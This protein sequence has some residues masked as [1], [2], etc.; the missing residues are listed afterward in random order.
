M[1]RIGLK[2]GIAQVVMI[3]T[4]LFVHVVL[5]GFGDELPNVQVYG[6]IMLLLHSAWFMLF[7]VMMK[8]CVKQKN[9]DI[10]CY[11]SN[12]QKQL[13]KERENSYTEKI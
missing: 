3:A 10:R 7:V 2:Y 8:E 1:K 6:M 5:I 4:W 9:W 12:V 11:L 13:V